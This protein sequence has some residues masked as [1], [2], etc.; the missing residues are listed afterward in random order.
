M[1]RGRAGLGVDGLSGRRDAAAGGGRGGCGGQWRPVR[2]ATHRACG[3]P[4]RHARRPSS[5]RSCDASSARAPRPTLT[6]IMERVV[7]DGHG[8]GGGDPRLHHRGQDGH[9]REA[10]QRPLL[11][12][13]EQRVVCR[14]RAVPQAGAGDHRDDRR[15]ARRR[16]QRR[17]RR[18]ADFQA[19]LPNPR[20]VTWRCPENVNPQPP[21]LINA[22]VREPARVATSAD[23]RSRRR[24]R[25]SSAPRWARGCRT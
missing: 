5:R 6:G 22:A 1:D 7:E 8:Q 3:R 12:D 17:Q 24:F 13:R 4:R 25:L 9:R 23:S 15:P 11:L 2:R 20:S 10:R 16:Q 21:I 19:R 14:V 18:G